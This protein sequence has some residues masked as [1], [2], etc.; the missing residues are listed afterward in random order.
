MLASGTEAFN[1]PFLPEFPC[2][3]FP[4]PGFFAMVAALITLLVD[5]MGTQYYERKQEKEATDQSD[6]QLGV[7]SLQ[8]VLLFLLLRKEGDTHSHPQGHGSCDGHHKLDIG[9][10]HGH[11]P[12]HGGLELGS[13]TRHIVVLKVLELGIVSHFIIIGFALGGCISQAQFRNKSA[14]IMACFFSHNTDRDRDTCVHGFSGS[15]SC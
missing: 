7:N 3:K 1:N 13:G 15:H 8:G 10:G 14:T 11:G 6:E 5:F 2:S 12:L 4:F 9:H